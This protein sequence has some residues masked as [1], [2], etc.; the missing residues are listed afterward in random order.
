MFPPVTLHARAI[1]PRTV[2]PPVVIAT[3]MKLVGWF[4]C[5]VTVLGETTTRARVAPF[6]SVIWTGRSQAK[7]TATAHVATA[8]RTTRSFIMARRRESL[9]MNVTG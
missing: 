7:P 1:D 5:S 3:A 8:A 4:S 6:G 2:S 9:C